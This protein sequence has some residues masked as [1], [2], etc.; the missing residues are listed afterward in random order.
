MIL[1]D[2]SSLTL[3]QLLG[4]RRSRR[5]GRRSPP[6]RR[7]ACGRR[8][9]WSIARPQGD[10]PVYGINTGFGSFADVKIAPTRSRRCSSTCCAATPP[11]S[12]SR[13]RSAPCARRWRCA[14]TCWPRGSPA[15]GVETLEA[16]IA[17]LNAR[18]PS[19]RA[20]ARIGRRQRRPRA[21][22]APRAGADRRRRGLRCRDDDRRARRALA[23]DDSASSAASAVNVR[24]S[25]AEALRRAGLAP[26]TLGAEGRARPDQRHAAVHRGAGAGAGRRR[27]ARARRRHR[28]RAVDRRAARIDPSVRGADPRRRGRFAGQT[29][30]GRQHRRG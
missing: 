8:A 20:V 26:V 2:G 19:A 6:T 3:E 28:R 23:D 1:L 10:E 9:P 14:P 7:R 18:R 22:R 17:L 12:A 21:A 11:A 27:T 4:D 29:V 15:F 25:G 30:V 5:A 16:L 24:I 13:C